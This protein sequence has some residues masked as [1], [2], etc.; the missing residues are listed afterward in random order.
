M[1]KITYDKAKL[2]DAL[3]IFFLLKTVYIQTYGLEGITFEFSNFIESRFS[4]SHIKNVIS[5]NPDQ[6]IVAYFNQNPIGVAEVLLNSMCPIRKTEVP[7]LSKLYVLERFYG[8]GVGYNL[9]LETEKLL[10][11]EGC[12]EVNLEVWMEN[13][14][15]ISFY[16]RF[17]FRKL[18]KVDFPMEKNVYNNWVMNK[19]IV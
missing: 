5:E 3:R 1:Q 16:D 4:E 11:I 10:R 17:G 7:E 2:E 8:M 18:G 6:L 19:V 15:A 12:K 14:R 13:E 9:M